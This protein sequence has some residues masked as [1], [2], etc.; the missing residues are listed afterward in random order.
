MLP[1][2]TLCY[3]LLPFVTLCYPLLPCVTP[4]YPLL[5]LV[6]FCLPCVTLWYPLLPFFTLCYSLL[7]FVTLCYPLFPFDTLCYPYLPCVT[8][9]YPLLPCVTLSY[10]LL[11]CVTPL[12]ASCSYWSD[13]LHAIVECGSAFIEDISK[14]RMQNVSELPP[15]VNIYG[16]NIDVSF[17]LRSKGTLVCNLSSSVFN[18]TSPSL[19]HTFVVDTLLNVAMPFNII[20]TYTNTSRLNAFRHLFVLFFI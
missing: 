16:A 8:H 19:L 18:R 14:A 4:C 6:T 7:P 13:T 3:L 10:P 20:L 2:V 17:V 9:C 1:L 15:T 5:T 12:H 11:P